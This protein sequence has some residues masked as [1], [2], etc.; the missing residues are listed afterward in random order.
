MDTFVWPVTEAGYAWEADGAERVLVAV[1]PWPTRRDEPTGQQTALFRTFARLSPDPEAVLTFAA[2]Y[3]HLGEFLWVG[4]AKFDPTRAGE[5]EGLNTRLLAQ[6]DREPAALG[7]E[8]PETLSFW[9]AQ[10]EAMRA[11][12]GLWDE[13]RA[14][15]ADPDR[16]GQVAGAIAR[17][18]RGRVDDRFEYDARSRTTGWRKL[19]LDLLGAMWLQFADAVA[20]GKQVRQ[21]PACSGWFVVAPG[22][23]R[24]DKQHC[25]VNCRQKAYQG[26]RE[27]AAALYARNN[28]FAKTAA[29]LDTDV[30]T[31]KGWIEKAKSIKKAKPIKKPKPVDGDSDEA[32]GKPTRPGIDL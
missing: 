32:G 24:V 27:R 28:S 2:R 4:G 23:A 14:G 9:R 30:E 31:V 17:G 22:G 29:E 13:I 21:C 25:S 12:D 8:R 16:T 19:P 18:C 20:G 1:R 3:G 6:T 11:A 10:I 15:K 7:R 5:T 26:R